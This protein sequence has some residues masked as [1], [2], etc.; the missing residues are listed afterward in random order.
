MYHAF[1]AL[2]PLIDLRGACVGLRQDWLQGLRSPGPISGAIARS[3]AEEK[4]RVGETLIRE[5]DNLACQ[6][7]NEKMW[8]DGGPID[9]SPTIDQAINGGYITKLPKKEAATPEWAAAIEALLLV[10]TL[11]GPTMFARIGI[12]RALNRHVERVFD[13]G[14][15]IGAIES[16][17]VTAKIDQR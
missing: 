17:R 16:W 2:R 11:G 8:S 15:R 1:R 13:P 10:A 4:R 9:P 14:S 5:A 6:S 3:S 12:M 7:W